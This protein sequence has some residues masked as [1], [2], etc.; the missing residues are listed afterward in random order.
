MVFFKQ[1]STWDFIQINAWSKYVKQGRLECEVDRH[2][3]TPR[4]WNI[5]KCYVSP[6][7]NQTFW[8]IKSRSWGGSFWLFPDWVE[9]KK[10]YSAPGDDI[11]VSWL[12]WSWTTKTIKQHIA[13]FS[14]RL[15]SDKYSK[16][17]F[18]LHRLQFKKRMLYIVVV[19]QPTD[20]LSLRLIKRN[21]TSSVIFN[22]HVVR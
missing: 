4:Y 6:K 5:L 16:S 19:Y 14:S 7:K 9:A 12:V 13:C 17:F 20:S 21:Q 8:L 15:P 1:G 2:F 18:V 10:T 22:S 11:L 3:L